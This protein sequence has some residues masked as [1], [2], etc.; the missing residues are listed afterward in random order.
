MIEIYG[1][2]GCPQCDMAKQ[3]CEM[4]KLD[5]KYLSMGIDYTR[6]ELLESF[7]GARMVPQIKINNTAIG[8]FT[9][10]KKYI[11]NE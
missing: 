11:V 1:K 2:P 9:E 5:Y 7:P 3:F 6:E 8:G 4:K 10:L